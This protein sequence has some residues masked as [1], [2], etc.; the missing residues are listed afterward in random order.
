MCSFTAL[1]GHT[2][3][4]FRRALATFGAVD[5]AWLAPPEKAEA[6]NG[7][8]GSVVFVDPKSATAALAA[9]EAEANKQLKEAE[10][11]SMKVKAYAD[12][13]QKVLVGSALLVVAWRATRSIIGLVQ[14]RSS[15]HAGA[16]MVQAIL[17][18]DVLVAHGVRIA[19]QRC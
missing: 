13:V 9:A 6:A 16:L 18:P 19:R 10:A 12:A 1:A 2:T 4:A 11:T 14:A 7:G 17:E 3:T 15:K 8:F 5:E